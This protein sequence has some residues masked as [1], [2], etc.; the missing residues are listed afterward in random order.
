MLEEAASQAGIAVDTAKNLTT[1]GA[2]SMS[3]ALKAAGV[4]S[5]ALNQVE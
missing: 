1:K 2:K 4:S 3:D 5:E